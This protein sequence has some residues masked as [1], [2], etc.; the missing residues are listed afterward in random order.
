M[1]T[2][3]LIMGYKDMKTIEVYYGDDYR[4]RVCHVATA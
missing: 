2:L 3:E 4:L 1:T